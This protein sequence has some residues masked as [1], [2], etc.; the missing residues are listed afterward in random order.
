[1]QRK[2]VFVYSGIY[3]HIDKEDM[4]FL[5]KNDFYAGENL[6]TSP[7]SN[8]F[9]PQMNYIR[10]MLVYKQCKLINVREA[11]HNHPE[12]KCI[13]AGSLS[14]EERTIFSYTYVNSMLWP[15]LKFLNQ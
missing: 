8:V 13:K 2:K 10:N 15:Q 14:S 4:L 9:I 12:L 5:K 3:P 6:K 11:P 1:M 7:A